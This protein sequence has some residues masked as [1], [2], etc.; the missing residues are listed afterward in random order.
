MITVTANGKQL[1]LF[2][3][4]DINLTYQINNI[5]DI[6]TR[7]STYSN[8]IKFPK[9][10]K[11]ISIFEN[12]GINGNT[13]LVPYKKLPCTYKSDTIPIISSGYMQVMETNNDSFDAAIFDGI[14]NLSERIKGQKLSDLDFGEYNHFLTE[15]LWLD[16]HNNLEG[17]TYP[18]ADYG[19]K[20]DGDLWQIEYQVP[21]LFLSTLWKMIFKQNGYT[22]EGDLFDSEDFKRKIITPNSGIEVTNVAPSTD[23]LDSSYSTTTETGF[24]SG[25]NRVT[26][27]FIMPLSFTNGNTNNFIVTNGEIISNYTGRIKVELTPDLLEFYGGIS[28]LL[29]RNGT[30]VLANNS[31]ATPQSAFIDIAVGDVLKVETEAMSSYYNYDPDYNDEYND[32]DVYDFQNSATLSLFEVSGGRLIDFSELYVD[33]EQSAFI[34]SIMQHYGLII[35]STSENN[36]VFLTME[37]LLK[38]RTNAEDWTDKVIAIESENYSLND[39]ARNNRMKF[40]YEENNEDSFIPQRQDG[41]LFIDNEHLAEEKD[42]FTSIFRVRDFSFYNSQGILKQIPLWEQKESNGTIQYNPIK[43]DLSLLRHEK[44]NKIFN[45]KLYDE[46]AVSQYAGRLSSVSDDDC[47]FDYFINNYY[48]E[49]SKLLNKNKKVTMNAYLNDIDLMNLSFN[50]LKYLKQTGKYYYLNSVKSNSKGTSK[51]EMFELND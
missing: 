16:S 27:N 43:S 22:F 13:S 35:T 42:L 23:S 12:L 2:E 41:N 4:E 26:H 29:Y 21:A 45:Y 47:D 50:R 37:D 48:S 6:S 7:N 15:T 36:L 14:I 51:I 39:Y 18:F 32:G 11:N 17:Y 49:L 38:N 19:G 31:L 40:K 20:Y 8:T 3:G 1:D 5:S 24:Y 10:S 30:V 34:K 46:G 33:V 25:N 28:T 44:S 9:T